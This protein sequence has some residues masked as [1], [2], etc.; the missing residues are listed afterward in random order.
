MDG[1]LKKKA[2]SMFYDLTK[3]AARDSFA[4]TLEVHGLTLEEWKEI[5]REITSKTGID[6]FYI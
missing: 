5:K 6:G 1:E 2:S 4:D 3:A